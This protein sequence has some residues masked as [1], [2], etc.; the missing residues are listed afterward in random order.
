MGSIGALPRCLQVAAAVD[1]ATRTIWYIDSLPGLDGAA[2]EAGAAS[3]KTAQWLRCVFAPEEEAMV[4]SVQNQSWL[5]CNSTF[6]M[7]ARVRRG[8]SRE[9]GNSSSAV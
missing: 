8:A 6:S 1:V 3:T 4:R 9:C 5:C 7:T 2:V